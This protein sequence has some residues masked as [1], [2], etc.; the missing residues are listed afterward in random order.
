MRQTRW[1]TSGARFDS[2]AVALGVLAGLQAGLVAALILF[3]PQAS[4]NHSVPNPKY[5]WDCNLDGLPDESC[6]RITMAGNGW[7]A[8]RQARFTS[9]V[10]EWS[11]RT[12]FDPYLGSGNLRDA[13]VDRAGCQ[14]FNGAYAITCRLTQWTGTF[15]RMA[16]ADV[17]FN[18][19][20]FQWN[21]AVAADLTKADFQGVA[22]HELGHF[23]RLIDLAAANCGPDLDPYTMCG[24]ADKADTFRI[25]DLETDDINGTNSVY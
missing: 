11:G 25:R 14:A 20:G 9:A 1:R 3:P 8:A 24:A 12:D 22:V 16:D 7:D 2:R 17:Y 23:V 13:F 15:Y 19:N 18:T 4:A 5:F 6:V 21:T 10:N